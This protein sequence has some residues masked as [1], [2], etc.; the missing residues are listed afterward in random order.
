MNSIRKTIATYSLIFL[1]ASV[2]PQAGLG[3]STTHTLRSARR[4]G[5]IDRVTVVEEASGDISHLQTA[6]KDS[7]PR[8]F[9][10]TLTRN[11]AY[12]ERTLLVPAAAEGR[13]HT[14]RY[15]DKATAD[16]KHG[17]ENLKPTLRP[18]RSLIAA[19]VSVPEALLYSPRGPLTWQEL[20]LLE[21]LGNTALLD[22]LLPEAPVA[23]NAPWKPSEKLLRAL[24]G[25]DNITK[26]DV[27]IVLKEVATSV[28]R[29]ELSGRVE[30]WIHGSP[31]EIDLM[32]K[33]RFDLNT[34]R[35]DWF[36]ALLKEKREANLAGEHTYNLAQKV[37]VRI[38]PAEACEQ[39]SDAALKDLNLEPGP[40]TTVLSCRNSDRGWEI[41]HDRSWFLVAPDRDLDQLHR[42]E[43][44]QFVALCRISALPRINPENLAP[45]SRFREDVQQRL[46]KNFGEV[47]EKNDSTSEAGFRV[48][49][50]VV[51]GKDADTPVQWHYYLLTDKQGRQLTLVFR[52][53]EKRAEQFGNEAERIVQSVRFVEAKPEK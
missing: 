43:R 16:M 32:A 20:E 31:T 6:G 49:R 38:V 7:K 39:L 45:L 26:S 48:Y 9:P 5:Q 4:A 22:Q 42:L 53:E 8:S 25:W 12:F 17:E 51:K 37:Q 47:V 23:T 28:A 18:E 21:V 36:A 24:L 3:E 29:L 10:L 40:A 14:V 11:L 35:I 46:G 34:N 2:T 15:Y 50:L 19:S 52:V 27:Q 30:G 13:C 1:A 41:V 33:C 44:G